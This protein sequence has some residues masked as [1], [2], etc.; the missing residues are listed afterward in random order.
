MICEECLRLGTK[1]RGE[2]VKLKKNER[3]QAIQQAIEN[4]P[5]ITDNELCEM[6]QVSIQT[7]RLD[8]THLNIPELRKRVKLVAEHNYDQIK[9]I[10]A[11]EIIGDLVQLKPNDTATSMIEITSDSVF[12][13]SQIARG[14]VL[15]AQAN[16]LCVALIH[17]P[18][19][20]TQESDVKFLDKVKLNDTVKAVANV[21]NQTN[22]H[23]L[24]EV[25]SYVKDKLVFSGNFKMFYISEDELNG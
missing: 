20:L 12:S 1:M 15:F 19:V 7:I 17:N 11:N 14:H 3:R 25:N 18:T 8:R 21:I 9:S 22:K 23:Y 24:I 16:S 4:N 6:F 2:K 13:K 5:F 10:E